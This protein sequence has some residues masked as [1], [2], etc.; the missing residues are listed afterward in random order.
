MSDTFES[1]GQFITYFSSGMNKLHHEELYNK[2]KAFVDD[3][4]ELIDRFR[5]TAS[6]IYNPKVYTDFIKSTFS[7]Q[8]MDSSHDYTYIVFNDSG[9]YVFELSPSE[10][11][12]STTLLQWSLEVASKLY[13]RF[14]EDKITLRQPINDLQ[15][16]QIMIQ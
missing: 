1:L 10:N 15:K 5:R 9:T 6:R 14:P 8:M 11:C 2:V 16:V 7:P 13:E 3:N 4:K 12:D